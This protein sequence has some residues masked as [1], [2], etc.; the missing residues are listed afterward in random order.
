MT[1]RITVLGAGSWGCTVAHLIAQNGHP[2]QLWCRRA[3]QADE[4]NSKHTN[5]RY[6][7]DFPLHEG[8]Q[9]TT[10]LES[11]L[12]DVPLVFMIVPVKSFR[13]VCSQAA[14]LFAPEQYVVHGSKGIEAETFCRMSEVI[15][16]ETCI[17][18]YGVLAG[19][20]IAT[21]IIAGKPA[22]AVIASRFPRVVKASQDALVSDRFRIYNN[23]DVLGVELAGAL[24]NIVAIASGLCT[25]FDLGENAR[26]LLITRGLS[27]IARV[28]VSLGADP[29]T[30]SGVAGAGDLIVTCMSPHSRN[31]RVGVALAQGK[32]LDAIIQDLG[33]VAEGVS[34]TRVVHQIIEERKIDAPLLDGMYQV[35]EGTLDPT[36]AVAYFMTLAARQDIDQA[37]R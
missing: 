21:E 8:V 15:E 30:F 37:L 24:K 4:I 19:P 7:G 33:M 17:R 31:H 5:A 32:K 34:T 9:A 16:Q 36:E 26:A 22:G 35:I 2:V 3:D 6:L 13:S 18:Q 20:N 28:G 1:G 11:V 23:D 12:Y 27:E 25:A 14:P 10:D 29:L